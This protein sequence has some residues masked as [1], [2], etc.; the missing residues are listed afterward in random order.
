MAMIGEQCAH[1][2]MIPEKCRELEARLEEMKEAYG[3]HDKCRAQ[4]MIPVAAGQVE[5]M[6]KDMSNH[7]KVIPKI[8]KSITRR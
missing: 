2:K 3:D 1:M 5:A 4:R 6:L 7:L 8:L